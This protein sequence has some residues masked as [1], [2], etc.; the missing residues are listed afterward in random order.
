MRA[1]AGDNSRNGWIQEARGLFD[2][3]TEWDAISWNSLMPEYVRGWWGSDGRGAG[4][5]W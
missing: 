1:I 5:V 3:R 4:N 2:S